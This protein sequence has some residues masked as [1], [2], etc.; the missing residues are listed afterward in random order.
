MHILEAI[1]VFFMSFVK[2]FLAI[3]LAFTFDFSF[4]QTFLI[5]CF[6]GILGVLFFA[7]FRKVILKIYYKLFP[8]EPKVRKKRS[9]KNVLAIKTAKKYGLFGI[10]FLTPILFSIPLGTFLALHFFPNKKKTLPILIASVLGWSFILTLAW[11]I[12]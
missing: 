12:N 5:T 6:G 3:P 1:S 2:F 11:N 4:W 10:A 9:L 7:Q 8:Y